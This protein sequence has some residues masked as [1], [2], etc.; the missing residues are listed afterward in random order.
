MTETMRRILYIRPHDPTRTAIA[1]YSDAFLQALRRLEGND[2]V[3]LLGEGA[4]VDES[5]DTRTDRDSALNSAEKAA[6][7]FLENKGRGMIIHAEMG[8]SLHREVWAFRK[9]RALL[10]EARGVI[11]VH[12]PPGLCSNPYRYVET[13]YSGTTPIRPINK[14]LTR[15]A[16]SWVERQKRKIFKA[17]LSQTDLA[18]TLSRAGALACR[19]SPDFEQKQIM[20]IPMIFADSLLNVNPEE[21]ESAGVYTPH[22]RIALFGFIGPDKGIELLLEAYMQMIERLK[23]SKSEIQPRLHIFGG[24][25]QNT[26]GVAYSQQL[27]EKVDRLPSE[28]RIRYE[29]GFVSSEERDRDLSRAHIQVVP[30]RPVEGIVFCSGGLVRAL[31]MGRPVIASTAGTTRELITDG[32]NGLLVSPDSAKELSQAM[33]RLVLNPSLRERLGS[34]ARKQL[35]EKHGEEAIAGRMQKIYDSLL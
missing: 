6:E 14:I 28:A 16:E 25:P 9:V 23:A 5:I 31:G 18:L 21:L 35:L 27:G 1:E 20:N 30:Y 32:K 10:P 7:P 24:I 26:A 8:N 33:E 19:D 29:P 34:T 22:P 12:D 13:E 15:T 4:V 11:T 2:V 3:D 17:L